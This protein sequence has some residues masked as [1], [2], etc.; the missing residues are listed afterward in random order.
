LYEVFLPL[1]RHLRAPVIAF[2]LGAL[3]AGIA[4]GLLV[5]RQ[6]SGKG[7]RVRGEKVTPEYSTARSKKSKKFL[8]VPHSSLNFFD[9]FDLEVKK[10]SLGNAEVRIP[11]LSKRRHRGGEK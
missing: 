10:N 8:R 3:C 5:Y 6:Q 1:I 4:A 7:W 2:L 9:L 11:N